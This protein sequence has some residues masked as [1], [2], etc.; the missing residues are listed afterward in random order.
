MRIV[1]H[2]LVCQNLLGLPGRPWGFTH[3]LVC[4]NLQGL[5]G[6]SWG[7]THFSCQNLPGLPGGPWGFTCF[8]LSESA[9]SSWWVL[10]IHTHFS[11]S[12]SAGSAWWVLGIHIDRCIF[13]S[14]ILTFKHVNDKSM[15]YH[16]A[17]KGM[18]EIFDH[19]GLRQ[20]QAAILS[21]TTHIMWYCGI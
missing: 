1:T 9:G 17:L 13:A 7:F 15:N 6:G 10:G 21:N 3:I 18:L 2:I 8:S 11:L 20:Y 16:E 4:H 14:T 12:E 19:V 5:P